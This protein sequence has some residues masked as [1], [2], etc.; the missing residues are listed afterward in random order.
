MTD[1]KGLIRDFLP[2]IL[3]RQ[4]LKF[5]AN[6]VRFEG[7]YSTW[8]EATNCASGYD[9]EEI[10]SKVLAATLQVKQGNA[11]FER[12]SVL[13]EEIEYS[14]PVLA[15]LMCAAARNDGRLNVLDFGGAL[16]S[17]YFQNRKFMRQLNYVQW[18][19]VEQHHFVDAGLQYIQDQHLRFYKSIEDCLQDNRINVVLLSGVLQYLP[20]PRDFL[21]KL[22]SV[23]A[24]SLILDRTSFSTDGIE[25]IKLQH[26]PKNIYKATYPCHIFDERELCQYISKR[27]YDMVESFGALD[28][29][30]FHTAWRGQIFHNSS[31][32]ISKQ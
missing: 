29:F 5:R 1:A 32:E 30:D 12:D 9:G 4:I 2:P 22:I 16:G 21:D 28:E 26:V 7:S 27:G 25:T 19:V 10:L 3:H 8:E 11:V 13:F 31:L 24:D 6:A 15:G 14:W 18:N 23:K 17:S 20:S